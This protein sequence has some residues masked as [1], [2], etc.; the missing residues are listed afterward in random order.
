MGI[1][2]IK[3]VSSSGPRAKGKGVLSDV[4]FGRSML[5]LRNEKNPRFNTIYVAVHR[6]KE[7]EI[8]F[9]KSKPRVGAT[10]RAMSTLAMN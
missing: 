7:T 8:Q 3:R 2:S 6:G 4:F 1:I 9:K 5:S 10:K